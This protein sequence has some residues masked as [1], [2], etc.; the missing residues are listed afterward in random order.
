LISL[1]YWLY[2]T[3]FIMILNADLG[4]EHK[5]LRQEVK[6]LVKKE[7]APRA[8][9]IDQDREYPEDIFKLFAKNGLL[10]VCLPENLGG[11]GM[12]TLA[13]AIAVEEVARACA[14]SAQILV[15]SALTTWP[16][17]LKG[18]ATLQQKYIPKISN[19]TIRGAFALTEPNA[20]SDLSTMVTKAVK[21]NNSY[22]IHGEKDFISGSL[23][24]NY[25]I[26]FAKTDKEN[27]SAFI[28]ETPN[29]NIVFLRRDEGMGIKGIPHCD[30]AFD[31]VNIESSGLL[32]NEGDGREIARLSMNAIQPLLAARGLGTAEEA[33]SFSRDYSTTRKIYQGLLSDLQILQLY[34][35]EMAVN[36]EAT[37]LL[38][39]QAAKL[40]DQNLFYEEENVSYIN[41]AKIFSAQTAINTTDKAMQIA[42]GHGYMEVH[43]LERMYRDARHLKLYMGTDEVLKLRVA[44][45]FLDTGL[46]LGRSIARQ[47]T[48]E[49]AKRETR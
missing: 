47:S 35:A 24:S 36:I 7:V 3:V 33:L 32:G 1:T 19:G 44:S 11:T 6:S 20:S 34:M 28:I 14:S 31:G 8:Y 12:G 27:M 46:D 17:R 37:R 16:L 9:E 29:P 49:R 22:T 21:K 39:Y 26:V 38:T 15:L 48:E 30:W 45:A 5:I 18:N 2:G 43:P 23:N 13:L 10:S 41:M 40:V 4:E 25:F 42:G